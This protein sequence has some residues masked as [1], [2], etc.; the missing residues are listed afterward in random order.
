MTSKTQAVKKPPVLL[1][2][3][4]PRDH[5][6]MEHVLVFVLVGMATI[7]VTRMFLI[8]TGYPQL[9]GDGLHIAHVLWGGA[10]LILAVL[11]QL[12]FIDEVGKFL[13]EDN[14]Y[15][16][17]PAFAIMYASGV[18]LVV[19][20][21]FVAS[22]RRRSDG[23]DLAS[24]VDIAV[25]G[26]VG[27]LSVRQRTAALDLIA[28]GEGASG[29]A[30]ARELINA[31]H[32][33]EDEL[34]DPLRALSA[35]LGNRLRHLVST[36]DAWRIALVSSGVVLTA[37]TLVAL[38]DITQAIDN[39]VAYFVVAAGLSLIAAWALWAGGVLVRRRDGGGARR[40]SIDLLRAAIAVN[41]LLT[42][43]AL[44]RF[45]PW[46]ATILVIAGL[47]TL[48]VLWAEQHVSD[49]KD[50]VSSAPA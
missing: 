6:A 25:S 37:S 46:Q 13:T 27:G 22:R 9:G 14:N 4:L 12:L 23:E 41:L 19:L 18:S 7:L 49:Q 2:W 38:T 34:P 36:R 28:R 35:R 8:A 16:Y 48:A 30:E 39:G 11:A 20:A 5:R 29:S 45:D 15:F 3:G 44:F 10:L 32:D 17:A 42:Q 47:V 26:V 24:A 31:I 33:D 40:R 43:V 1:R 21:D 50:S